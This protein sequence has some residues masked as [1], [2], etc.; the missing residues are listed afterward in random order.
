MKRVACTMA[1]SAEFG[2]EAHKLTTGKMNGPEFTK[3]LRG[4]CTSRHQSY[5]PSRQLLL[6][7]VGSDSGK[8]RQVNTLP[9]LERPWAGR[10]W[11]RLQYSQVRIQ[12]EATWRNSW[13]EGTGPQRYRAPCNTKPK[14]R[15]Y[16]YYL[17]CYF[18]LLELAHTKRRYPEELSSTHEE[19]NQLL[20]FMS[21]Y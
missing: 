12:E 19:L 18:G 14:K 1:I 4:R 17:L 15:K 10:H 16:C 6:S 21:G 5:G 9:D 3:I 13:R 11:A 7:Q 2:V 8:I 20:H